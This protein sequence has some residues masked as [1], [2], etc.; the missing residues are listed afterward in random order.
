MLAWI[1]SFIIGYLS[2][3]ILF[4]W[5][6]TKIATGKDIREI[7]DGN[8]GINNV[9]INVGRRYGVAAGISD[10]LKVIIPMLVGKLLGLDDISLVL[11]GAGGVLGHL[12]P[13]YFKFKGGRGAACILASYIVLIPY[14]LLI[15]TALVLTFLISIRRLRARALYLVSPLII[16]VAAALSFAFTHPL[17]IRVGVLVIPTLSLLKEWNRQRTAMYLREFT[18]WLKEQLL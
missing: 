8:P 1:L 10:L 6:V 12:Y 13:V 17:A 16:I 7:G 5:V 11:M 14:E 15:S 2:G 4:A 18:S 9:L 3:S